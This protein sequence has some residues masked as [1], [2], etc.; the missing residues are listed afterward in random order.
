M[1]QQ[2]GIDDA[3]GS[4]HQSVQAYYTQLESAKDLKTSACSACYA[5]PP[6][7]RALL[8]DVP[9]EIKDRWVGVMV[10]LLSMPQSTCP[11]QTPDFVS[12]QNMRAM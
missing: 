9:Q 12:Y 10:Q 5:P 8:R 7:I 11:T 4:V 1:P 2:Q 6:E 3:S